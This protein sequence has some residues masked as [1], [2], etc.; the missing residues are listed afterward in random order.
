MIGQIEKKWQLFLEIEDGGDRHFEFIFPNMHF[1]R[2]RCVLNQS[3][4]ITTKFDDDLSISNKMAKFFKIQDGGGC[5]LE[6]WLCRLF[7]V[8]NVF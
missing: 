6:L 2:H 3:S 8:N 7:D 4:N 1:R 5:H